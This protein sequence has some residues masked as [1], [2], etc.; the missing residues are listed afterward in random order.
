MSDSDSDSKPSYDIWTA[1]CARSP[2]TLQRAHH[3]HHHLFLTRGSPASSVTSTQRSQ[4]VYYAKN[5][6]R[7]L[8]GPESLML[9]ITHDSLFHN[10]RPFGAFEFFLMPSST[11][12]AY[13]HD[14]HPSTIMS[15]TVL[16]QEVSGGTIYIG[17]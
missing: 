10:T 15:L 11:A 1:I 14:H 8:E 2:P 17:P 3:H 13:E 4:L 16:L 7:N 9:L 12:Y 6:S 5:Y